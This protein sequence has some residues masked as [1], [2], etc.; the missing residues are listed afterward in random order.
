MLTVAQVAEKLNVTPK[1]VTRWIEQGKLPA[2]KF[3][4]IYRIEAEDF[5]KFIEDSKVNPTE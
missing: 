3:G 1:T 4:K 2:M 5:N